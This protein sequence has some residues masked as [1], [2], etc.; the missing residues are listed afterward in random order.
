MLDAVNDILS[1]VGMTVLD[2]ERP[3]IICI[4]FMDN[5]FHGKPDDKDEFRR[6]KAH[7][8]TSTTFGAWLR[9]RVTTV[10]RSASGS[11]HMEF[12]H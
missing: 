4:D 10:C 5:P 9:T 11:E 7:D 12:N 2:R 8:R 6:M 1:L 3:R